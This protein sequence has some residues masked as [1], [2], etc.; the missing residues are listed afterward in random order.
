[1]KRYYE[2]HI[3]VERPHLNILGATQRI[4][5]FPNDRGASIVWGTG[6]LLG[7]TLSD[8]PN[9]LRNPYE[10]AVIQFVNGDDYYLDYSSGLTTD[11]FRYQNEE[12]IRDLLKQ[13]KNL[14]RVEH[15]VV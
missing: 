7:G 3:N 4:Y 1:M 14:E 9:N 11:V 13:I 12:Q 5:K 6:L 15:G 8:I 10:L 2:E